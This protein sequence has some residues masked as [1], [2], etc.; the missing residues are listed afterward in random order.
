MNIMFGCA[1]CYS[2]RL[3]SFSM[4]RLELH[5]LSSTK[6]YSTVDFIQYSI[7]YSLIHLCIKCS[8][9]MKIV[10][11]NISI[12][13]FH[14]QWE[15]WKLFIHNPYGDKDFNILL[16]NRECIKW[17]AHAFSIQL[18][19]II[20]GQS[21]FSIWCEMDLFIMSLSF[22][23]FFLLTAIWMNIMVA[24]GKE[25]LHP[26]SPCNSNASSG[27]KPKQTQLLG[28]FG[29]SQPTELAQRPLLFS[30]ILFNSNNGNY[31]ATSG[32]S[33]S[34]SPPLLR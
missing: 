9:N 13:W 22:I 29:L 20:E 4:F 14:N 32:T 2:P 19:I 27:L 28:N 26:N 12:K 11:M 25:N 8:L 31:F 6:I 15:P 18:G 1:Y 34:P 24:D 33:S 10:Y 7:W 17:R 5:F 16:V 3:C 21:I 30:E 23:F